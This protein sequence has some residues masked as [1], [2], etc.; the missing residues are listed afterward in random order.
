MFWKQL[1]NARWIFRI[2]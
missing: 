2:D 1:S